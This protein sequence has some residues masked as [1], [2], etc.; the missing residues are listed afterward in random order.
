MWNLKLGRVKLLAFL[1]PVA[2][3]TMI[4]LDDDC[5]EEGRA[6][7]RESSA[8]HRD[9]RGDH[10]RERLIDRLISRCTAEWARNLRWF[11]LMI[12]MNRVALIAHRSHG[13]LWFIDPRELIDIGLSAVRAINSAYRTS[14]LPRKNISVVKSTLGI[15]IYRA[16]RAVNRRVAGSYLEN[17]I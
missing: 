6:C 9:H 4:A 5:E 14:H 10:P 3:T 11:R 7:E 13:G 12:P 8:D 16:S 17:G 15:Q 2:D 1:N